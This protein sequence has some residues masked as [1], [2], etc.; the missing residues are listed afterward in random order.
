VDPAPGIRIDADTPGGCTGNDRID[1]HEP[2]GD[3]VSTR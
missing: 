2:P 1:A 3:L